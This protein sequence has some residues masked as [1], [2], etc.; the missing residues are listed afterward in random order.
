MADKIVV[1]KDGV[2]EQIGSPLELYD[3]PGEHVRRRLHRLAGDELPSRH[4][5]ARRRHD[6]RVR[7]RRH[8]CRRR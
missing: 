4:V 7:G 2:V 6:R 5:Q 3:R 1:L 8:A